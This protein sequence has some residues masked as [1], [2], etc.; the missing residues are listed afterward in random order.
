MATAKAKMQRAR[1]CAARFGLTIRKFKG[2]GYIITDNQ[3]A[4]SDILT[5]GEV[6]KFLINLQINA[7]KNSIKE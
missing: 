5:F 2:G 6:Q 1:Y 7:L 4:V 3:K